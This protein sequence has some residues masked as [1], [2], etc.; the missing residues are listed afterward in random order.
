VTTRGER[1]ALTDVDDLDD[2]SLPVDD[3]RSH[4]ASD[5]DVRTA[6]DRAADW[7][8]PCSECGHIPTNVY[9]HTTTDGGRRQRQSG[10]RVAVDFDGTLTAGECRY[11]EGE[12]PDP[13]QDMVVFTNRHYFA[14]DTVFIWTARTERWRSTVTHTLDEWDVHYHALVMNKLS[15]DLYVDD[16]AA[17]PVRDRAFLSRESNI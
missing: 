6:V 14:G 7:P 12:R 17:H 4:G 2:H 11:W 13:D 5:A 15:A 1:R 3:G 9:P 16:R 10:L 8:D